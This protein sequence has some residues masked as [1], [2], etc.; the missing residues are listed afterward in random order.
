[1]GGKLPYLLV[2]GGREDWK[3]LLVVGDWWEG[4]GNLLVVDGRGNR[5]GLE[6]TTLSKS[7]DLG[8]KGARAPSAPSNPE[9]LLRS[10]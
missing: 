6:R 8:R 2:V 3:D 5:E 7:L 10:I 1:V 4:R 9:N